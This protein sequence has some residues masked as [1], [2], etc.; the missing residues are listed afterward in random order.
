[1]DRRRRRGSPNWTNPLSQN[2]VQARA[3]GFDEIVRDLGLSID[4]YKTSTE[5]KEWVRKNRDEKYVPP[6]LLE[7]WEFSVDENGFTK[8]KQHISKRNVERQ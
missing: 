4:E 1:M 2:S 7:A 6:E 3:T 8:R 5:L